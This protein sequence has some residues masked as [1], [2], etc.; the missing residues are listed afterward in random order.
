MKSTKAGRLLVTLLLLFLVPFS[1]GSGLAAASAPSARAP[2]GQEP[3]GTGQGAAPLDRVD[4]VEMPAVDNAA[5]LAADEAAWEPGIAPRFAVP[6]QTDLSPDKA[7]TWETLA[8]DLLLWR[9]RI[10]SPG[11]LSLNL[12]FSSYFMP[13]GGRLL[14]Y[15]ADLAQVTGPFSEA[16][17]EAHGQLWTP[18]I[19]SDEIVVQVVVPAAVAGQLK[20]VIG[21]VNHGY[22]PFGTLPASGSCNLDVVCSAAD[23]FPQVD[24]W[25]DQIRSVAVIST[26]GSTFCTGFLVNNTAQDMK[27]FFMTANH[28]GINAGNAASLVAYWNYQNSSCRQPGSPASGGPGDGTL[29]Q[30]NTGSIFRAASSN[31]DFTLVELDDPIPADYDVYWAGW[32]ATGGN[33]NAAV[34]I[35]HPDTDEK[36]ISFEDDPA[37]T[38]SYLGNAVPGDGTHIR[39][40]DWDLGTTEPGSS[41]S[42]L[43]NPAGRIVGQLH[44]GYAACGNDLSDW[45]GRFSVSW[46]GGGASTNRLK[47]WLDPVGGG[48][49][50]VLDGRNQGDFSL[51]TSPGS[52][53]I[54]APDPAVYDITVVPSGS[55]AAPVTL[56]T[57]GVPAG[58]SSSFAPNPASPPAYASTLTIG[59]TELAAPGSYTIAITGTAGITEATASVGLLIY[60]AKPAAPDLL[61]PANGGGASTTPAFTWQPVEQ[62]GHYLIQIATDP[63]FANLVTSATVSGASYSGASLNTSTAY[64]WRVRAGNGC[65]AGPFSAVFRFTTNTGPG[66]CSRGFAPNTLF[67]DDFEAQDLDW[68]DGG[69][70]STWTTSTAKSHSGF[71]A[72][73]AIDLNA[74]SDQWLRSP[75]VLLPLDQSPVTLQFWNWQEIENAASGCFDGA[76]VEIS[77]DNGGTWNQI[78]T[79]LLTDPYDGPVS[80]SYDNPLAGRNA[81]CGDPQDWLNSIVDLDAYAGQTVRFRFRLGTDRSVGKEGWFIDDVRVQSCRAVPTAV[82]L[83]GLAAERA[84]SPAAPGLPVAGVALAALLAMAAA[85]GGRRQQ[86]QK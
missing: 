60:S 58:A 81:W 33:P 46:N 65:G 50:L 66:D 8:G 5:L 22:R 62:A 86:R 59:Q 75:A 26:G 7:G 57:G 31:S 35:H 78:Q 25:R 82:E 76:I 44:G 13:P 11:A 27:P 23:G 64:F 2:V 39:I 74:V 24:A 85:A 67:F 18:L 1:S 16:D 47:D 53:E 42:P 70:G 68:L 56:S 73:H 40:T 3:V 36:R 72:Y 38:T 79:G 4:T 30:F 9:L 77:T 19:E 37:S 34:T 71:Y 43:F 63:G 49:T 54:C 45:Y 21:S 12:G 48:S 84:A 55:F 80:G 51:A 15:P 61:Q 20:L 14:L 28:C 41:G 17:N 52:Q 69:A 29:N 10:H 32:D 83:S 6:Q